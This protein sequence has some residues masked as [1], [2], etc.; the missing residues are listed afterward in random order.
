MALAEGI[1]VV[2]VGPSLALAAVQAFLAAKMSAALYW[3]AVKGARAHSDGG[4]NT[5]T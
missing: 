2:P 3:A 1:P 5:L 4:Y